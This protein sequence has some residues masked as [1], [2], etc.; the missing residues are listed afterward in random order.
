MM[1]DSGLCLFCDEEPF[2]LSPT[3]PPARAS[4]VSSAAVEDR[5]DILRD[6]LRR[7][8][9][10]LP[11]HDY[12]HQLH[13]SSYLPAARTRAMQY[14]ILVCNRL[15]LATGTAFNA[16][17]YLDRFISMNCTVRWED[18]MME[19]LSVACLSIASKMD[20]VSMPSLHDLQMEELGHSFEARTIQ[21][22]E[23]T[24][25]KTL[26]W[27]LACITP[28]TYVEVFTWGSSHVHSPYIPRTIELLLCALVDSRFLRFHPSTVAASALQALAGSEAAFS[29]LALPNPVQNMVR[30][31]SLLP[32]RYRNLSQNSLIYYY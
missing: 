14:I 26:D 19:L 8:H 29:L 6:L 32:P 22:M 20:E 27:R 28:Y 9:R 17:N 4:M 12:S 15:D 24:V 16:V 13:R 21:Q 3:P 7:E 23:L 1:E 5:D 11:C 2:V 10:Y 31:L 30:S 25:L 18:W